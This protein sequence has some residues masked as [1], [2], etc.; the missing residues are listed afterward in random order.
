MSGQ[1]HDTAAL[2]PGKQPLVPTGW[3]AAWAPE[4]V[5]S[6]WREKKKYLYTAPAGNWTLVIQPQ[7]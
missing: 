1:L 7:P 3:E 2:L 6:Q 4:V 5:W